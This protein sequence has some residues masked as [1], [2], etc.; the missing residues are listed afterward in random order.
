MAKNSTSDFERNKRYFY[1]KGKKAK[2][3]IICL[4][5]GHEN[6]TTIAIKIENKSNS[7]WISRY[8]KQLREIGCIDQSYI[9]EEKNNLNRKIIKN[10]KKGDKKVVKIKS[11][12]YTLN[13]NFYF[14]GAEFFDIKFSEEEKEIIEDINLNKNRDKIVLNSLELFNLGVISSIN[15]YAINNLIL[16][17][18]ISN[19]NEELIEKLLIISLKL[20]DLRSIKNSLEILRK[21][22]EIIK[23]KKLN[24][25]LTSQ[26]PQLSN[27][28]KN[29]I[30][31]IKKEVSF[32]TNLIRD[33]RIKY[34]LNNFENS[35]SS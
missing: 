15:D 1:P 21:F 35:T 16:Q 22:P 3:L 23:N 19:K 13:M 17:N 12:G 8:T 25:K 7:G 24:V 9:V 30:S 28:E 33:G 5:K 31:R 6:N 32:P 29:F 20:G 18:K 14:Q 34:H 10:P 27:S 11:K 26:I 4:L 2:Q